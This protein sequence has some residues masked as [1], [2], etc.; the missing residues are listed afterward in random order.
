M[1][2]PELLV[3]LRG[4]SRATRFEQ[5]D[6]IEL[7][8][9]AGHPQGLTVHDGL[10]WLTTVDLEHVRGLVLAF[11]GTG[12]LVHRIEVTDG[13]RFHPGGCDLRGSHLIVPVAEYRPGS[14]TLVRAVDLDDLTVT[15]RFRFDDH[16]GAVVELPDGGYVAG[17][18]GSRDLVRFDPVGA[19]VDRRPNSSHFVDF[20]DSQVLDADT[21]LCSG[22][23]DILTPVGLTQIGGLALLDVA[24]LTLSL[25]SPVTAYSSTGR[26]ITYNSVWA[27]VEGGEVRLTTVPDDG[28]SRALVH[29]LV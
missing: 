27:S 12:E 22:V 6:V 24:T 17:T 13:E 16:L 7:Q 1:E 20:Q 19:V 5:L 11:D 23:A 2:D 28:R 10:H 3:A 15:D 4:L 14:T 8:F 26:T 9:D 18:W 25:E 29:R 21:I